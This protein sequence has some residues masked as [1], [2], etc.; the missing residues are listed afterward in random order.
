MPGEEEGHACSASPVARE[1]RRVRGGVA[2][3]MRFR[4]YARSSRSPTLGLARPRSLA[5]SHASEFR[6]PHRGHGPCPGLSAPF[7]PI[8]SDYTRPARL[9]VVR[10]P[11]PLACTHA[12]HG[13]PAPTNRGFGPAVPPGPT[14]HHARHSPCACH[15]LR[16]IITPTAARLVHSPPPYVHYIQRANLQ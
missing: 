1:S 13:S 10:C 5:G 9:S 15:S 8:Y 4:V 11:W 6:S 7:S 3:A 14:T 12:P 16:T 2:G